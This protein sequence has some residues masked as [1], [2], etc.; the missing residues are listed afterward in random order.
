MNTINIG[1]EGVVVGATTISQVEGERGALSYRGHSIED[2]AALEVCQV[3]WLLLFGELPSAQQEQQL[4]HYLLAHRKLDP[5]EKSLLAAIPIDTHPMLM[6][7]TMVPAL[8]LEQ[9]RSIDLPVDC[10]DAYDG[11]QVAARLPS[12]VATFYNRQQGRD[13]P[14]ESHSIEPHRAF[15]K[16]IQGADPDPETLAILDTVQILQ[17][18]H[19]YNAGTFAGRVVL[20]TAAPIQSVIAASIGA[21]FG[22][23][24]GGADEAAL[25]MAVEAGAPENAAAYVRD[26][27]SRG[28]RIMGMGHREYRTVDPR[29]TL[30]K[31]LARRICQDSESARLL[32][33]LEA[34]EEAS[35]EQL[36]KPGR[37]LRAN[38][39]FYKGAV[40][41]A[42][43]IPSHFFTALFAMAR[44][45]GYIAHAIEFRPESRLIRPSAHY[46]GADA[47]KA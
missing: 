7:Q 32:A 43:G 4:A 15:L 5:A 20:S 14:R 41:H 6:L 25:E 26:R 47:Q 45:Y 29:A 19:S 22:E 28:Q 42:L 31:P 3:I 46:V 18:E 38:V 35:I 12:L 40:F 17:M 9:R 39:D 23:L 1:L 36:Q 33:T 24:H 13:W 30:I 2:L 10:A 21:L 37:A 16:S 34:I 44:V 11:L 27:L 8:K